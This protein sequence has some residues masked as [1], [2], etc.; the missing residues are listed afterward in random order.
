MVKIF[1]SEELECICLKNYGSADDPQQFTEEKESCQYLRLTF[2]WDK[3][4]WM[5]PL[6]K[7]NS[8]IEEMSKYG[9]ELT[10]YDK[11]LINEKIDELDELKQNLSR[12]ERRVFIPTLMRYPP[13]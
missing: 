3:H 11:A 10:E 13:K 12:K 8:V 2:N 7:L 9:I 4:V 1:Y 6:G 5:A